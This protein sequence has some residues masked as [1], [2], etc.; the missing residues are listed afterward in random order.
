MHASVPLLRRLLPL[1]SVAVL[2]AVVYDGWIFYS[3]WSGARDAE[4]ARQA[5]EARRARQTIDLMGGTD[6]R[7]INFYAVPQTIRRGSQARIC[8]GVYGAKR[9]RVEPA[10]EDLHPGVSYCLQV[11]PRKDT[12]YKLIAEDGAGHSATA[13]LVI[14]VVP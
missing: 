3:R 2:A 12:A 5:E 11:A 13:S 14:K 9:V 10:V 1:L 8:Y 6:F 4:R 7:I